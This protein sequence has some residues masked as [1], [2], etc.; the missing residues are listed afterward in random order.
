M[1]DKIIDIKGKT[2]EGFTNDYSYWDGMVSLVS[3][4]LDKK[5]AYENID[6]VIHN[7]NVQVVWVYTKNFSNV[8]STNSFN[9]EKLKGNLLSEEALKKI[10]KTNLFPHFFVNTSRG[11]MEIRGAPIQATADSKR[12]TTPSGFLIAGR[13]WDSIYINEISEL[14]D[15]SIILSDF[16]GNKKQDADHPNEQDVIEFSK[17]YNG[18]DGKPLVFVNVSANSHIMTEINQWSKNVFFIFM[19]FSLAILIIIPAFIIR[20]VTTPLNKISQSLNQ[21]APDAIESLREEKSEFGNIAKLIAE[22]FR[23]RSELKAVVN[24]MEIRVQERTSEIAK[25]NENLRSEIIEREKAEEFIKNILETVDEGFIVVDREYRIISANNAYIKQANIPL[26][27]I[28][29]RHCYEVSHNVSRPC[30]EEGE[31]CAVRHTFSSGNPHTSIH[32]HRDNDNRP[33]YVETK[34]YPMKN[35]SGEIISAIEIVNN[36]TEKKKLEAQLRHSQKMEA[37]GQLAGG[38]AHD[39]NNILTAII[40]YGTMLQRKVGDNNTLRTY[41]D[42][43]L[44]SAERAG[45]LTK[46]L[47][48]FSRKQIMEPKPVNLNQLINEAKKLLSKLVNEKIEFKVTLS[49]QDMV[50]MADSGQIEQV[51]MNLVTNAKDA[52]PDGG[53]LQITTEIAETEDEYIKFP[54]FMKPGRYVLISISDTGIGMDDDTKEKIFEP[55]FTTK[56]PGKGTG[57]GLAIVYGIVKQHNGYIEVNSEFSQGTTFK[58]YLPLIESIA[59]KKGDSA[60]L[61]LPKGNETILV[62]EDELSVR[63]IVRMLLEEQGY[64][65]IE[66]VNGEDA[67][68]KFTANKDSIELILLDLMMPQKDGRT[69]YE[70][71]K[72]I[73]PGIKAIFMSGYSEETVSISGIIKD[74]LH[75]IPKPISPEKLL[76][77]IREAISGDGHPA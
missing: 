56:D 40:G 57:L 69:V 61:L 34:T 11:L 68:K 64:K 18:W 47:L 15:G 24:E 63:E 31:D 54:A 48:A 10:F 35:E 62:A 26:K 58:I 38:V 55:F 23:Q 74:K 8:Y 67:V 20:W 50:V 33:V 70:E 45:N 22:F 59:E 66:A 72:K 17:I 32:T 37:V 49:D 1:F 39:F 65:V 73:R 76:F 71:I 30:Y 29:G 77:K 36:I 6:I 46:S 13:L 43:I 7:Y 75:F 52:M 42:T 12:E 2:L 19:V 25:V 14:V 44:S 16:A 53:T 9:D 3:Q 4:P 21:D 60:A 5:W 41:V 27:D 51:L 28:I